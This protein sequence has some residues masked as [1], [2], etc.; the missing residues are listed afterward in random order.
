MPQQHLACVLLV[1]A[2]CVQ[3]VKSQWGAESD[4][5]WD[6]TDLSRNK[7]QAGH[8]WPGADVDKR[9]PGH[10]DIPYC[11]PDSPWPC[12]EP[13]FFP[14]DAIIKDIPNIGLIVGRSMMYRDNPKKYLNIFLGI[15]YAKMPINERR[16]K[17]ILLTHMVTCQTIGG[18]PAGMGSGP[19]WK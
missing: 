18:D 9:Y 17:V 2:Y 4:P 3:P 1:V 11:P 12:W 8:I 10:K 7:R 13:P 5:Q 15:P 16:F 19:P 6:E 14:Y